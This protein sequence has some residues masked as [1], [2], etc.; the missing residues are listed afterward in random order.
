MDTER[1]RSSRSQTARYIGWKEVA[2]SIMHKALTPAPTYATHSRA[3]DVALSVW[4]IGP[5]ATTIICGCECESSWTYRLSPSVCLRARDKSKQDSETLV[6][7]VDI[8][9]KCA[10]GTGHN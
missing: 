4:S 3:V 6:G 10:S 7:C 1:C 5:Q 9:I 8:F 2:Q